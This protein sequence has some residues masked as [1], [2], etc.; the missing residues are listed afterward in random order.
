MAEGHYRSSLRASEALPLVGVGAIAAISFLAQPVKFAT[1]DL[2]LAQLVSVGATLFDAS[3]LLQ[4]ALALLLA[5]F[6][7]P[8]K[9]CGALAWALLGLAAATLTFQ[10]FALMPQFEL[11]LHMLRSA[12]PMP[13]SALHAVY[14]ALELVKLIALGSLAFL[15]PAAQRIASQGASA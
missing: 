9:E 8:R 7:A 10:H 11:R 15:R 6:S 5:L 4:L 1:P 2:T 3:H 12:Q 14:A 13:H